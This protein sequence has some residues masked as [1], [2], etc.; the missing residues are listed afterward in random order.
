[1]SPR[2]QFVYYVL[3][4][5]H[6]LLQTGV[7]GV[8]VWRK[9]HR[10]FPVFFAYI[11]SQILAFSVLF[12]IYYYSSNFVHYFYAYWASAAI[13]V[14]LGFKVI[15]EIFVDVFRPYHALKDL[16]SVLFKW[17]GLVMLL[18][19]GV[20]AASSTAASDGPIVQAILTIQTSVRLIQCG[21]VLFLLVF[22]KYLGV[23][24][25]QHSFGIALGFGTFASIE[26]LLVALGASSLGV[27][28]MSR[29]IIN[30]SAYN[31]AIVVWLAYALAK[32]PVRDN[33][34]NMLRTQRWEQSLHEIQYPA[35]SDSLIPM[36]EGMVDRA[37]SRTRGNAL[38][39]QTEMPLP[40][41]S[42]NA[43]SPPD[44]N[45]SPLSPHGIISKT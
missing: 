34:V 35:T 15:H 40:L 21:L 17:A 33:S 45:Y 20:V 37:L 42:A 41:A 30:M 16:G 44:L 7:A 22:S 13:S 23:S 31:C 6:P 29:S 26:L 43:I 8:M 24:W 4:F 14:V 28:T 10:K 9:L 1:M 12:P 5:A 11:V 36:F 38:V 27:G 32:S 18:V 2:T 39:A 3:W 19:A 25:R